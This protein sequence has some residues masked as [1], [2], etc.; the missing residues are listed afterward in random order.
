MKIEISLSKAEAQKILGTAIKAAL[1]GTMADALEVDT[2]EW[3]SYGQRVELTLTPPEPI[4][5]A[6]QADAA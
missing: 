6:P 1:V 4:S 2:V 5:D 3:T